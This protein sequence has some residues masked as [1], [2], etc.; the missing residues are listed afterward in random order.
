L[1]K[2][3]QICCKV[4]INI[5]NNSY[6]FFFLAVFFFAAFFAFFAGITVSPPFCIVIVDNV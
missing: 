3:Q 5:A 4:K 6:F 2:K 1:K